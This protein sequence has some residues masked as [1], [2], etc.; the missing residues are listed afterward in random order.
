MSGAAAD[1]NLLLGIIALQMDFIARDALVA[2]MHAWV[3][4][5]AAPLSQILQDQGALCA[6]RRSLLDALVDEHIKLHDGDPQKSLAALSPVGSVRQDL[7]CIADADVQASLPHVLI[8]RAKDEPDDDPLRTLSVSVEQP[9]AAGLR[10]RILRPHARGGL[11]QVSVALDTE[12]DRPVALK[13]IQDRHAD[14]PNSR[15]RFVAEAEITGKLEHPGI[16]PVYS[17]G[18]DTSGRPFYAMR[19]IKGDSLKEAIEAFQGDERLKRRPSAKGTRLRELLRRF[20]DVCDA[21]AYAHS[22]GVLHRDLKPGNI[23]LGPYGETLV[24]DWGLAKLTGALS[25]EN[26]NGSAATQVSTLMDAPI[27]LSGQSGSWDDTLAGLPIGTPAFASPEQVTGAQD[28]L[29]PATDVYG[30]GATLYNL[31]T[32]KVP[33]SS[34]DLVD[35]IR[36]VE[37]GDIL[38]PRSIDPSIS[39]AL[40]AICQKAMAVEPGNRYVSARA[41]ADDVTRWLDDR[42]VNAYRE[43][44]LPRLSRW[45]RRHRAWAQAGVAALAVVAMVAS[46]AAVAIAA[47]QRKTAVALKSE[48]AISKFYEEYV[49]AAARPKGWAG[50]GGK[51]MTLT[52]ALDHAVSNIDK[53]FGGEPALEAE[54][55]H[56]LGM[57]YW[58]L[59]KFRDAN[60]LLEKAYAIRLKELGLNDPDTL[61][62]LHDLAMQRWKQGKP[63]E[64]SDLARQALEKRR[65]VLGPDHEDTLWTQLNLGTFLNEIG[66]RPDEAEPLLREAIELC[67]RE[68]GPDHHHTLYGQNDLAILLGQRGKLD[69]EL[70]LERQTLAGRRRSLG[71]DHPDTL[72]SMDNLAYTLQAVGKLEEADSL[73]RQSLEGRRRVLGDEHME[74][75]WA[76]SHLGELMEEK[77]E[78]AEAEKILRHCLDA[79]RRAFG[80]E[81]SETLT[82]QNNLANVL[83]DEGKLG[84]AETLYRQTLDT[85]RRVLGPEDLATLVSQANLA[86]ILSE[87]G[88]LAEAET[89][90]RQTLKVERRLRGPENPSTLVT[91]NNLANVLT[92]RGSLVEAETLYRQTFEIDRRL[93]G[94]E[95]PTTLTNQLNLAM[96]LAEQD[97]LEEAEKMVR[98]TLETE[99]RLF[100]PEKPSTLT[101]QHNLARVLQ[102]QGIVNEAESL[103]RQ[104]L[105]V[106]RRV[107][108][109]ENPSTLA[110]QRL[111]ATVLADQSKLD[112]AEKLCRQ[113]LASQRRLLGPENLSTLIT[114]NSLATI[115]ADNGKVEEGEKLCRQTLESQRG[116]LGAEDP[117]TLSTMKNLA[118][119]LADSGKS[120]EA[121]K[122]FR[123]LLTSERKRLGPD[124]ADVASTLAGLGSVLL[125][126]GRDRAPEA[127]SLLRECL[128]IREKKLP[129]GHWQLLN[130]RS[131]LGGSLTSQGKFV[132][133]ETLLV[134]SYE[135]LSKGKGATPRRVAQALG[136]V[137]DLYDRWGKPEKADAWR[138]RR[139]GK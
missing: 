101:V 120:V 130:A 71:P 94:P 108:G 114:Q 44:W 62:S 105:E 35:A 15:A 57:T 122:L 16:V 119:L 134:A 109:P 25:G 123:E 33:V 68:L 69:E 136:R 88:K 49:L 48:Q 133:A 19:F 117:H 100:G 56:T 7:S 18:H 9:S 112:E 73:C 97:K 118:N 4:H 79:R 103:C 137:I 55:R 124:H 14:D 21:I 61:T 121:E 36:R 28:R 80:P 20:T 17:L 59:G 110:S 78:Y 40:E 45:A 37:R 131:L 91:Q 106:R 52:E 95:N 24:V 139:T 76:E 66:D 10:F 75:L 42:P 111:L 13:E 72:R 87:S 82:N 129:S 2:A 58:Y 46:T 138:K 29:G 31:L 128:A 104:T 132:A 86:L 115:L 113:T 81:H 99:R 22:R 83:R 65:R 8:A 67:K 89:L 116:P 92:D 32:G 85:R 93:L 27:K 3:L 26:R 107:L 74:T 127:E 126:R 54:V 1:R 43:P 50:G 70:L 12:L 125:D 90:Y 6:S 64:A 53:A 63:K 39:R 102:K 135:G 41:L 5:K 60:P 23:M 30:L 11:G 96:V 84:E 34:D 77:G 98:Q 38:A 47:A 51:D